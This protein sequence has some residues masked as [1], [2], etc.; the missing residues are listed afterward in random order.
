[1]VTGFLLKIMK[2]M[3][4]RFSPFSRKVRM[5][6]YEKCVFDKI[7]MIEID[8]RL[9]PINPQQ[10]LEAYNPLGKVPTLVI[11]SKESYP[12]SRLIC[13]VLD[14]MFPAQPMHYPFDSTDRMRALRMQV[15]ADGVMEAS[16]SYRYETALRPEESRCNDWT[17]AL[18]RKIVNTLRVLNDEVEAFDYKVDI[19]SVALAS[20]LGYLDFRMPNLNWR[21]QFQSLSS[22]FLFFS[23]RDS[24]KLTTQN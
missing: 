23:N 10:E 7:E 17:E 14:L 16:V 15:F 11:D 1:M 3:Y 21:D 12:D 19:G 2:L 5:V 24:F 18:L 6:L 20:A 8:P 9:S 22:F 13:E 4:A